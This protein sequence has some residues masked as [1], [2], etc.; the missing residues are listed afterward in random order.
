[1]SSVY[2]VDVIW[3]VLGLSGQTLLF[4]LFFLELGLHVGYS[5]SIKFA[6]DRGGRLNDV[7]VFKE[8]I[9][10]DHALLHVVDGDGAILVNI[11]SHPGSLNCDI[12]Q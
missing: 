10:S 5:I 7:K 8:I 9:K 2:T 11:K 4:V 6:L 1:M 3:V 12:Y